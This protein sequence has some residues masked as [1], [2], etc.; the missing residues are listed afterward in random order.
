MFWAAK[1]PLATTMEAERMVQ[2]MSDCWLLPFLPHMVLPAG[3]SQPT[4]PSSAEGMRRIDD[5]AQSD[6]PLGNEM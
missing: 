3:S 5:L 6:L 2:P 4:L 1:A